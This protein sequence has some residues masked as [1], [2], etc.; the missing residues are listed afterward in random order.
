MENINK[1]HT[2]LPERRIT[3]KSERKN[4]LHGR[5]DIAEEKTPEL[6]DIA[7]EIMQNETERPNTCPYSQSTI[8]KVCLKL[9]EASCPE[10]ETKITM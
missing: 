9:N 4:T 10:A 7:I 2:E 5:L 1:V 6:E 8:P 3:S